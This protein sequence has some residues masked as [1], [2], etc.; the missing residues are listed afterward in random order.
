MPYDNRQV[1]HS[2]AETALAQGP[3]NTALKHQTPELLVQVMEAIN[4]GVSVNTVSVALQ[5]TALHIASYL[6]DLEAVKELVRLD[7]DIYAMNDNEDEVNNK[8]PHALRALDYALLQGH[9]AVADFLRTEHQKVQ[10]A[11]KNASPEIKAEKTKALQKILDENNVYY[12]DH[13]DLGKIARLVAE[14]AD[15]NV[16]GEQLIRFV[17]S[18]DGQTALLVV[19]K[20]GHLG[21]FID[22][23]AA[24]VVVKDT[25]TSD[26]ITPLRYAIVSDQPKF[27]KAL[28]DAGVDINEESQRELPVFMAACK[29]DLEILE[30]V[31]KAGANVNA[32]TSNG[33]PAL[34]DVLNSRGISRYGDIKNAVTLLVK[35]GADVNTTDYHDESTIFCLGP[36]NNAEPEQKLACLKI[37][38]NAGADLDAKNREG[39]TITELYQQFSNPEHKEI[40][41][42]LKNIDA[43]RKTVHQKAFLC[44]IATGGLAV[45]IMLAL[46][47]PVW[48]AIPVGVACF[49]VSRPFFRAIA[50]KYAAAIVKKAAAISDESVGVSAPSA[51]PAPVT[52]GFI[53]GN[54]ADKSSENN[55]F[56]YRIGYRL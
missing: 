16:K 4:N 9:T 21:L 49:S 55:G 50:E 10:A 15:V 53:P 30:I 34:H 19:S 7:A 43:Q 23:M 26:G 14:G 54:N 33:T 17:G 46:S 56:L 38:L 51:I 37:L 41:D 44:R 29:K 1:A 40:C 5:T 22:F 35:A 47:C 31:L 25:K 27:V 20:F 8:L 42:F 52:S 13:T 28:I 12:M 24:G 36:W 48:F 45:T 3:L 32:K 11:G 39:K 6:G 2:A 18:V